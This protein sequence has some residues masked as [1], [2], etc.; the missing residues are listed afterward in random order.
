LKIYYT[1]NVLGKVEEYKRDRKI[2][3]KRNES[4]SGGG[5]A[6]GQSMHTSHTVGSICGDVDGVSPRRHLHSEDRRGDAGDSL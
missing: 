5:R 3:R 1:L 4:M 6:G 2:K